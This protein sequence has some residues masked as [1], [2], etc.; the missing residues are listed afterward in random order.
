MGKKEKKQNR[1]KKLPLT[2]SNAKKFFSEKENLEKL[3][4]FKRPAADFC[5]VTSSSH[6][7]LATIHSRWLWA[8][9][10]RTLECRNQSQAKGTWDQHSVGLDSAMWA[11]LCGWA[12]LGL[13][14]AK[15][16]SFR[17]PAASL[18]YCGYSAGGS[19]CASA[20]QACSLQLKTTT[21]TGKLT[22][23]FLR[24]LWCYCSATTF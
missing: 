4:S 12:A 3:G 24:V 18:H 20:V 2:S 1:T 10:H 16:C 13:K 9:P 6:L 14:T 23:A 8:C 17:S 15:P 7:P 19:A 21:C 11:A 5:L 22:F